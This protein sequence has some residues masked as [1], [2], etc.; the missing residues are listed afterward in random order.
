MNAVLLASSS[1][2]PDWKHCAPYFLA[3]IAL[4]VLALA[5]PHNSMIGSVDMPPVN[6]IMVH[7]VD[8]VAVPPAVQS[9]PSP[10]ASPA[11]PQHERPQKIRRP[12]LTMPATNV[13]APAVFV[14]PPA[15]A[16]SSAPALATVESGTVA[17]P[18][19]RSPAHYN[20]AYLQNPAPV[21]PA[22]SRRLGEEGKVLLRVKVSADGQPVAV[23]LEKSSNFERLDEAA[24]RAVARWRF[25]PA[26]RGEEPVEGAVIV[27]I[28]FR[29]DD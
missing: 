24:R 13:P 15:P 22:L 8:R 1:D 27:P 29:L 10:S 26:K 25:V 17:A 9:S 2:V 19:A 6:Q 5:W 21:F 20:A 3:A 16:I 7:L 4:H 12:V 14:V 28:V 18:P 23:D 11:T